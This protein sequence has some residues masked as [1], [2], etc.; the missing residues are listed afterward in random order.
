MALEEGIYICSCR[1]T[2]VTEYVI[3]SHE[4][5]ASH[6]CADLVVENVVR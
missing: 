2:R 1:K 6:L 5:S 3:E 4:A